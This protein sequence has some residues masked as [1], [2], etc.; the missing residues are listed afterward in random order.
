MQYY[1][2][3]FDRSD[4]SLVAFVILLLFL[5]FGCK[6]TPTSESDDDVTPID[7]LL[8]PP[9]LGNLD[10]DGNGTVDFKIEYFTYVTA[11]YPPSGATEFLSVRPLST[12]QVQYVFPA[13][14]IPLRDSVLI[15]G[16]IGW[17]SY[18][19]SL[20]Q[21][22]WSRQAGWDST[23]SGPWIGVGQ[24]SLGLRLGRSGS[25]YYGWVKLSVFS[26]NGHYSVI[27][28]A[29]HTRVNTPILAGVR[30]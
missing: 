21:I 20:A 7:T 1:L 11:G 29:S 16:N 25:Y 22:H 19:V 4:A 27:D 8:P 28:S 13:G 26:S 6:K 18:Y 3:H 24:R 15:D 12:N 30:P 5:A 2:F 23:W 9:Q 10:L 17:S 14:A